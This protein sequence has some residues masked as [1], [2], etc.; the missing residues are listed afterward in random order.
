MIP[1][2][3]AAGGEGEVRDGVPHVH[4]VTSMGVI[5]GQLHGIQVLMLVL[6]WLQQVLLLLQLWLL[7]RIT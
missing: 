6:V 7:L 2:C 3:G 1:T 4:Q 5:M